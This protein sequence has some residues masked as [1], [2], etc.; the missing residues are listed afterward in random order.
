MNFKSKTCFSISDNLSTNFRDKFHH[1]KVWVSIEKS[2]DSIKKIND[3]CFM[4]EF[5]VKTLKSLNLSALDI[6]KDEK[7]LRASYTVRVDDIKIDRLDV[8][9][10]FDIFYVNLFIITWI[11]R[12]GQDEKIRC[13]YG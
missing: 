4:V 3:E 6:G 12:I 13:K 1:W 10:V 5:G 2:S 9:F 7:K 11:I 8:G